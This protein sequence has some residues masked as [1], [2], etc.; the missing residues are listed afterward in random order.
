MAAEGHVAPPVDHRAGGALGVPRGHVEGVVGFYSLLLERAARTLSR[1]FSDNITDELAGSHALRQRM[2]DAFRI[3]LGEVSRDGL[4]SIGTR[5]APACAIR[6]RRS[7]S[8]T[9]RSPG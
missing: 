2:L 9:A 6:G 4:V 7:W 3:E 1:L 8:T 5:A